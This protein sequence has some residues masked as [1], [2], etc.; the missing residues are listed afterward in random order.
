[1]TFSCEDAT[2]VEGGIGAMQWSS[3][4][5]VFLAALVGM[6]SCEKVEVL[7]GLRRRLRVGCLV[8]VRSARGLR[9][10]LYPVSEIGDVCGDV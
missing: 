6:R 10:V 5:V 1:M 4:D 9:G 3:F 8:V 2:R 7:R